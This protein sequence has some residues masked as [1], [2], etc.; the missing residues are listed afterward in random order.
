MLTQH[1][2]TKIIVQSSYFTDTLKQKKTQLSKLCF[3]NEPERIEEIKCHYCVYVFFVLFCFLLFFCFF[4][5]GLIEAM[6]FK[7]V[8]NS[9]CH[10]QDIPSH[11]LKTPN[12]WR[13]LHLHLANDCIKENSL[14]PPLLYDATI[15]TLIS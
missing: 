6:A 8:H 3:E 2:K 4:C 10:R 7:Q 5:K 9:T 13:A 12:P 15:T 14:L 11:A 1:C